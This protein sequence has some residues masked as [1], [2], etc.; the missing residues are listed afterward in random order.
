MIRRLP[1]LLWLTCVVFLV[2]LPPAARADGLGMPVLCK[3]LIR[4]SV[5]RHK[6][7][8]LLRADPGPYVTYSGKSMF[9]YAAV[10][11]YHDKLRTWSSKQLIPQRFDPDILL[12]SVQA[13]DLESI[14]ILLSHGID[15]NI[16]DDRGTTALI[17]AAQCGN[18]E[19]MSLLIHSG[20]NLH[21]RNNGGLDAMLVA[22]MEDGEDGVRLLLN[23]GFDVSLSRTK[24]GLTPIDVARKKENRA[25]LNLL[26]QKAR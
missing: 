22:I 16:T 10:L 12:A 18:V 26:T 15:P 4:E 3:D 1:R 2:S 14:K 23:S 11:G 21:A 19:A 7:E 20:A 13:G 8:P 5:P 9:Y 25:I 6:V 17:V 24:N